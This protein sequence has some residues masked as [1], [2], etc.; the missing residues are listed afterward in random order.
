M[1]LIQSGWTGSPSASGSMRSVLSA[2]WSSFIRTLTWERLRCFSSELTVSACSSSAGLLSVS[3]VLHGQNAAEHH[4]QPGPAER[5]WWGHLPGNNTPVT[6]SQDR[7]PLL[8]QTHCGRRRIWSLSPRNVEHVKVSW[9]NC[10]NIKRVRNI[11]STF[12]FCVFAVEV[13]MAN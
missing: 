2:W 10:R 5:L 3:G 9:T 7:S 13:L 11:Q 8:L 6:S 12:L 4:D 1:S